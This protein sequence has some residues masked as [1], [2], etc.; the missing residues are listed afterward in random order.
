[1]AASWLLFVAGMSLASS[2]QLMFIF[3]KMAKPTIWLS[4]FTIFIAGV[5][6][7]DLVGAFL[8][9]AEAVRA[10]QQEIGAVMLAFVGLA[11]VFLSLVVGLSL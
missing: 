9:S 2:A 3:L 11:G 8:A 4:R 1:M 10:Y 7:L 6:A 5:I